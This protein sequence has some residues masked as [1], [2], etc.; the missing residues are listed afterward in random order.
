MGRDVAWPVF[1]FGWLFGCLVGFWQGL[2]IWAMFVGG[3]NDSQSLE[4]LAPSIY[5]HQGQ[6]WQVFQNRKDYGSD[7]WGFEQFRIRMVLLDGSHHL[8]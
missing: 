2:K 3:L 8:Q 6:T 4:G 5:C 7:E 1:G